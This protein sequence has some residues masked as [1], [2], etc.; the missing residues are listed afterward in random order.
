MHRRGAVE[1]LRL[2]ILHR[3]TPN[4]SNDHRLRY[5]ATDIADIDVSELM[6]QNRTFLAARHP[7]NLSH[8][9]TIED[10]TDRMLVVT[11]AFESMVTELRTEHTKALKAE[12]TD[13]TSALKQQQQ[14]HEQQMEQ[15]RQDHKDATKDLQTA[16]DL[17][18]TELRTEHTK[19]LKAEG[20]D[21]TSALKQQCQQ[22]EQQ[23]EQLRQ[24]HKDATKDLQ[25]AHDLALTELRTE[26]TKALKAQAKTLGTPP[27]NATMKELLDDIKKHEKRLDFLVANAKA[28]DDVIREMEEE[29]KDKSAK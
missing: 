5:T 24:D 26:H 1:T 23:M 12:G 11:K 15:L 17:A 7:K 2:D 8:P 13:H 29:L 19:A 14:Q 25:T 18:L 6:P 9:D 3:E 22:H 28:Q 27:Y 20:T 21:H 16:H 4:S 10:R